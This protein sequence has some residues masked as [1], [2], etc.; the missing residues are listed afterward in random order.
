ML[1]L[2]LWPI[3]IQIRALHLFRHY[4]TYLR[5]YEG[6]IISARES[7]MLWQ[8]FTSGAKV[9]LGVTG[10]VAQGEAH[11]QKVQ[12]QQGSATWK[13]LPADLLLL[14]HGVVPN[15]QITRQLGCE[16]A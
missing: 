2:R 16:H 14:H 15:I 6:T 4:P 1:E 11:L 12:F 9:H 8:M 10:I 5:P 13:E 3:W 7:A